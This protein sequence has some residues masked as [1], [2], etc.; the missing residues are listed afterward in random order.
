MP[1]LL[2][3]QKKCL[4]CFG[5]GWFVPMIGPS[6]TPCPFCKGTGYEDAA[7]TFQRQHAT[8]KEKEQLSTQEAVL[9][10]QLTLLRH[11]NK[12]LTAATSPDET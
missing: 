8:K 12:L 7:E 11:L 4:M 3:L 10:E 5:S 1:Q 2:D 9:Q 6:D